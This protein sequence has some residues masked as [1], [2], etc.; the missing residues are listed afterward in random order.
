[1]HVN[2]VIN[3]RKTYPPG[4]NIKLIKMDDVQAPPSGTIG[5]VTCVDDI[6][7]IHM[8]WS[9]GSSLCLVSDIDIFVIVKE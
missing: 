3:L 4:T 5:T 2:N 7:N 1:M 6:G 8:K 9:N